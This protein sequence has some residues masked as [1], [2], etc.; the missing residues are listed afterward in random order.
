[1]LGGNRMVYLIL[2]TL[3]LAGALWSLSR[4]EHKAARL[5]TFS[6]AAALVIVA[7]W[8]AFGWFGLYVYRPGLSAEQ[9]VDSVLGEF[10]ADIV[11][12]PSLAVTLTEFLPPLAGVAA[13]TVMVCLLEVVF[14]RYGLFVPK[15]WAVLYSFTGFPFYF[16]AVYLAWRTFKRSGIEGGWATFLRFTLLFNAA[17]LLKLYLRATAFIKTQIAIMATPQGN[18]ALGRFLTYVPVM[19]V[20]G[21][22][23]AADKE[24]LWMRLAVSLTAICLINAAFVAFRFQFFLP[25]WSGPADALAQCA[26]IWVALRAESSIRNWEAQRLRP[27][28]P[29]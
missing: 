7:D 3:G 23:V 2:A 14:G 1:M 10:L 21:F 11:F 24:R 6:T 8:I 17:A 27:R 26:G 9:R 18:Q 4:T 20:L 5:A 15:G 19:L 22:W 25:P 28:A 16:W 12:V 29:A 13:G